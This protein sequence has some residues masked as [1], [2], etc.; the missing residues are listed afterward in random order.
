MVVPTTVDFYLIHLLFLILVS[1]LL[2]SEAYIQIP[3]QISF[4]GTVAAGVPAVGAG[5]AL[6]SA[7]GF[8]CG[9]K[10]S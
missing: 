2:Y 8:M 7:N 5:A 4:T 10:N 3:F 6:N 9:L 1:A